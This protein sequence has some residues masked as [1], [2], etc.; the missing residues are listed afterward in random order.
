MGVKIRSRWVILSLGILFGILTTNSKFN[1]IEK[2]HAAAAKPQTFIGAHAQKSPQQMSFWPMKK[3]RSTTE[4]R[5][6]AL[7]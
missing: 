4:S 6:P 1:A 5:P 7:T 3:Y 2:V